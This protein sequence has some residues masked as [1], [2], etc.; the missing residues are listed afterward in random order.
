MAA[1]P[2]RFPDPRGQPHTIQFCPY[3][4][5]NPLLIPLQLDGCVSPR[6]LRHVCRK[7]QRKNTGEEALSSVG[8]LM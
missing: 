3:Q 6:L 4:A 8:D 1:P 2:P 5:T 7:I